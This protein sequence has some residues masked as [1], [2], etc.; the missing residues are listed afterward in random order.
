MAILVAAAALAFCGCDEKIIE[1]IGDLRRFI[2]AR[3]CTQHN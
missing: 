1:A 3:H 2:V